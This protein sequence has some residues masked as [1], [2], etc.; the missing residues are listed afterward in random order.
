[1]AEKRVNNPSPSRSGS[2]AIDDWHLWSEVTRSVSPLRHIRPASAPRVE[3]EP[4]GKNLVETGK[5]VSASPSLPPWSPN[6]SP[7]HHFPFHRVN[8]DPV[9]PAIDRKINRRVRRGRLAI[10]ATI[11]LHGLHQNEARSALFL[12]IETSLRRGDRTVL[13][14]TG[15]GLKKN[16]SGNLERRGVLRLM[17]PRWLTDPALA[18]HI[19]GFETSAPHHGGEGAFYVRLKRARP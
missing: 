14:I 6:S 12:F 2:P 9:P 5:T 19:A 16:Q 17:L 11:D 7:Q 3:R 8:P 13:I 1:M 4:S 10:D 18:P 15:K